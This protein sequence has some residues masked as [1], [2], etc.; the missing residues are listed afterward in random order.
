[1][2]AQATRAGQACYEIV[3][4]TPKRNPIQLMTSVPDNDT[5]KVM[6]RI[7]LESE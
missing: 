2:P 3:C 6:N 5:L 7:P 4:E 1:M